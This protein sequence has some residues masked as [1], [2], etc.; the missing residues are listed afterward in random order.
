LESIRQIL[1][2]CCNAK[3]VVSRLLKIDDELQLRAVLLLNNWWHERNRVREGENRRSPDDIAAMCGRQAT[4]IRNLQ[5]RFSE[6]IA[7]RNQRRK[8]AVP[9]NGVLKLNVDGAFREA[10]KNGGWGYIFRD[11]HGDVVQSGFGRMHFACSPL[12]MELVA[13]IEGVK[14][15]IALGVNNAVLETDA[16]QVV[17][18]IQSNEFRLAVEGGLIHELKDLLAD[19]SVISQVKYV[20]RD[21]N[22]VAHELASLGSRSHSMA[23]SVMAGVPDCIMVWVSGDLA[24]MVE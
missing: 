11:D 8:W 4:E 18:A 19:S 9:P 1:A 16:Q 13:C 21:C 15:A 5:R 17:W 24:D 12:H 10:D 3:E 23:P 14:T 6:E 20:S 2:E 22:R 7:N